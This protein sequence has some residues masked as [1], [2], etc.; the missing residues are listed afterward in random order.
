MAVDK[1]ERLDVDAY[2]TTTLSTAP[3]ELHPYF[4][5]FKNL[6]TRKSVSIE[7]G[8][9]DQTCSRPVCRLWHQLTS[10]LFEFVDQPLSRPYCVDLFNRFVRDFESRINQLRLVELGVK[11]AKEIDSAF[12]FTERRC[13]EGRGDVAAAAHKLSP[14]AQPIQ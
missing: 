10:K 6:H 3:P 13:L 4:E 8:S 7:A 5:S 12:F 14:K 9:P 2:L 1:P 11:V